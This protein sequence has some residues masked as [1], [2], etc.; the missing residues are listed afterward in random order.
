[1]IRLQA[2]QKPILSPEVDMSKVTLPLSLLD[3]R[4]ANSYKELQKRLEDRRKAEPELSDA[5]NFRDG[6]DK[7]CAHAG[8]FDNELED[9]AAHKRGLVVLHQVDVMDA[10]GEES[11]LSGEL[12]KDS[13]GKTSRAEL[14]LTAIT[15]SNTSYTYQRN[16]QRETYT[17]EVN[18]A[19][20]KLVI[21]HAKGTL[22]FEQ[23]NDE[24]LRCKF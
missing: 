23:P 13:D 8:K 12:H 17:G 22:T 16:G 9:H 11:H 5:V 21:D 18:L 10:A 19:T 2:D 7:W 1:M 3:T 14:D 4:T 20:T 24:Y 6:I 15:R